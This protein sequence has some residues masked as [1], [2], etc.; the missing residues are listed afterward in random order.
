MEYRLRR[1][2]GVGRVMGAASTGQVRLN[3]GVGHRR[4]MDQRVRVDGQLG[5]VGITRMREQAGRQLRAHLKQ[6][7]AF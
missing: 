1:R 3:V 2:G 7:S 5:V 4:G 6:F